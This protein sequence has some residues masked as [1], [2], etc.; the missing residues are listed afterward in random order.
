M[1]VFLKYTQ[2]N[3]LMGEYNVSL[4]DFY[5]YVIEVQYYR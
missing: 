5:W 1:M 4:F 2:G 3:F